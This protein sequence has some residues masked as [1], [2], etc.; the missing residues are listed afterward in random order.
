MRNFKDDL[1]KQERRAERRRRHA[2]TIAETVTTMALAIFLVEL[3]YGMS[4]S[5]TWTVELS[6]IA[7]IGETALF[8]TLTVLLNKCKQ[9]ETDVNMWRF[10]EAGMLILYIALSIL[11]SRP[12]RMFFSSICDMGFEDSPMVC[13]G[14][15]VLHL[16]ILFNYYMSYR[17][18]Q[19]SAKNY[20]DGGIIL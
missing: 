14:C 13:V 8:G 12:L 10:I 4:V 16:A 5:S 9:K 15:V 18:Q 7:A 2:V 20:N 1:S 17:P 19:I 3:F 11:L 6:A